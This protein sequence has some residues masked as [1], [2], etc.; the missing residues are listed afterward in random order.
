MTLGLNKREQFMLFKLLDFNLHRYLI[1]LKRSGMERAE[2]H[3]EMSKMIWEVWKCQTFHDQ[4]H[5]WMWAIHD[6]IA[7]QITDDLPRTIGLDLAED[8]SEWNY[9]LLV[10]RFWKRLLKLELP[11]KPRR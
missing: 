3:I 2:T 11:S 9:D 6:A 5:E 7:A 8:P 1:S 10:D 4:D